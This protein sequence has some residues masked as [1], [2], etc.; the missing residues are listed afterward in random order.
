[1]RDFLLVFFEQFCMPL[2]MRP[3]R[4]NGRT[5]VGLVHHGDVVEDVLLQLRS[6]CAHAVLDS[7]ARSR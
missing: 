2:M 1:M 6:S 3:R 5:V 7:L 4:R